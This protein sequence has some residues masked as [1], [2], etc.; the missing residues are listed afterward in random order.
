MIE[1]LSPLMFIIGFIIFLCYMI[2]LLYMIKK[3][4]DDQRR[5]RESDMKRMK[6]IDENDYDGGGNWGRFDNK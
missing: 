4:H 3:S 6:N 5:R 2:R 1:M